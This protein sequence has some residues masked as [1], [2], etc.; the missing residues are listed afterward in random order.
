MELV[1]KFVNVELGKKGGYYYTFRE[2]ETNKLFRFFN[3]WKLKYELEKAYLLVIEKSYNQRYW[4]FKKLQQVIKQEKLDLQELMELESKEQ[5]L[6]ECFKCQSWEQL[7][8]A[9]T[10]LETDRDILEKRRHEFNEYE[11][12]K[13]FELSYYSKDWEGNSVL[14]AILTKYT[15]QELTTNNKLFCK[16]VGVFVETITKQEN[17]SPAEKELLK[18]LHK[19]IS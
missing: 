15:W 8:Q 3:K 4:L 18:K 2:E 11:R 13:K 5:L 19:Q 7:K 9:Q 17:L 10:E 16:I 6:S 12:K 14:N 1:G